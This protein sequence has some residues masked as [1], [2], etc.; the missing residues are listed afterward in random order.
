MH[1][2]CFTAVQFRRKM[3]RGLNLPFLVGAARH[4]TAES[5]ARWWSNRGLDTLTG[6]KQC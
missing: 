2:R 6:Q 4:R 3:E 1:L 5:D